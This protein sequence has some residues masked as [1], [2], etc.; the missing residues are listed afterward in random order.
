MKTNMAS[1]LLVLFQQVQSEHSHQC[2]FVNVQ[3]GESNF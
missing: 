2:Y 1:H 3:L